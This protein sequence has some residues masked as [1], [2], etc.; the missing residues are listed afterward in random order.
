MNF[1][2]QDNTSVNKHSFSPN[3]LAMHNIREK[4]S[5]KIFDKWA[6][7]YEKGFWG[8]YFKTAYRSILALTEKYIGR[9][10]KILDIGCGTG[11]LVFLLSGKVSEGE[12]IGLDI[13]KQMIEAAQKKKLERKINNAQFVTSKANSIPYEN[14]RFNLVFCLNALHHFPDHP[15]FFKEISRIL[16]KDGTFVLL[17]LI[18]D[19]PIRKM[20]ALISQSVIFREKEVEYHSKRELFGLLNNA[21]LEPEIKKLSLFFTMIT[22]SKKATYYPR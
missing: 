1:Y 21:G 18:K 8:F 16:K 10:S 2:I 20:W 14:E 6:P 7:S 22:I 13:S 19:N 4:E 3:Y 17:D 11:E 15:S 5:I 9:D 12:I